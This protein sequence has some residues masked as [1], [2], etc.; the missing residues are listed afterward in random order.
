M[1]GYNHAKI[2][3]GSVYLINSDGEIIDPAIQAGSDIEIAEHNL[4]A[5]AKK[6]VIMNAAGT[7]SADVDDNG[8]IGAVNYHEDGTEGVLISGVKKESGKDGIDSSTN[9]LQ[10][11]G[12]EHHEIHSGSHYYIEGH[13][14]LGIAGTLYAKIVTPGGSK[15]SHF[16][17]QISSNGILESSLYECPTG[18][19]ANGNRTVIHANNRNINSWCGRHTG[20]NE[21]LILTDS[22]QDWTPGELIGMQIFNQTDGSSAF[23]T[24]NDATTVTATLEGSTTGDNEWTT[25][26]VYEIGNSKMVITSGV[27][28][29]TSLGLLLSDSQVGG[30]GFKADVG[31]VSKRTDELILRQGSTYLRSFT[32]SSADNIISFKAS[33]YEH[34]D[35][36]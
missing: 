22:G 31:G 35:K 6:I 30:E 12:Y 20:A 24:D 11:I 2:I 8:H 18:G 16:T 3:D 26:D 1:T 15:W 9:T 14:T 10:T 28:V 34:T 13:A 29:A 7:N 4:T 33:W 19:M 17:W 21:A 23:I 27:T 25:G 36:N 32:S 5:T